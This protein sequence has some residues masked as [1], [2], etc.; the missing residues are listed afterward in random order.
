MRTDAFHLLV[1]SLVA[2]LSHFG[3]GQEP[4]VRAPIAGV[5]V[6]PSQEEPNLTALEKLLSEGDNGALHDW[7]RS[8]QFV[9][10]SLGNRQAVFLH[11]SLV[12][13]NLIGWQT[14]LEVLDSESPFILNQNGDSRAAPLLKA[15]SRPS[16]NVVLPNLE[17]A[18][19]H[20][21]LAIQRYVQCVAE[22]QIENRTLKVPLKELSRPF[23]WDTLPTIPSERTAA[24]AVSEVETYRAWKVVVLGDFL[25]DE[26]KAHLTAQAFTL[27]AE[28]IAKQKNQID[29]LLQ[30]WNESL[31]REAF[32]EHLL[33]WNSWGQLP[34]DIQETLRSALLGVHLDE[35]RVIDSDALSSGI[36]ENLRVRL[37]VVGGMQLAVR[38]SSGEDY[39]YLIPFDGGSITVYTP[40]V[41]RQET[42]P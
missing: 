6:L 29:S 16:S 14:L 36:L 4:A 18:T 37:K 25:T 1:L 19:A 23:E 5:L 31:S 10:I 33:A 35:E 32:E 30:R 21:V 17:K 3:W 26:E 27:L 34:P 13:S 11:H 12:Y 40:E 15:I 2:F 22:V 39:L 38:K 8:N 7:A 24:P 42:S 41:I 28:E 20:S 9:L